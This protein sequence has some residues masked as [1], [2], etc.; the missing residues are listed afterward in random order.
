LH[1]GTLA[2]ATKRITDPLT[3]KAGLKSNIHPLEF[4]P[5]KTAKI[6]DLGNAM[7]FIGNKALA[8]KGSGYITESEYN[9]I[10]SSERSGSARSL[11]YRILRKKGY[12]AIE[13]ENK[14]EGKGTS[15]E[16]IDISKLG[17]PFRED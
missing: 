3:G 9:R 16:V 11:L 17:S 7:D 13:Y 12:D 15:F 1:V 10:V 5:K 6:P 8:L 14:F 2:Q 4:R